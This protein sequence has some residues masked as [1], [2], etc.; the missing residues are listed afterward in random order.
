MLVSLPPYLHQLPIFRG[1]MSKFLPGSQLHTQTLEDEN[2]KSM[3][4]ES[5]HF[6]YVS[7]FWLSEE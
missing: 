4:E 7:G 6:T 3:L 5:E 1:Q 2:P